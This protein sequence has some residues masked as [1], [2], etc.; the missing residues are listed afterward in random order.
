MDVVLLEYPKD[1]R[2]QRILP[3]PNLEART[4]HLAFLQNCYFRQTF[5]QLLLVRLQYLLLLFVF[6]QFPAVS[7]VVSFL[8]MTI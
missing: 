1:Y 7:N 8:M 2:Y 4:N 3:I 6:L 5:F